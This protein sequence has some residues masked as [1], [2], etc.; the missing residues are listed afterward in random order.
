M[1]NR[2]LDLADRPARLS[3]RNSLLVVSF[4]SGSRDEQSANPTPAPEGKTYRCERLG[5]SDEPTIPLED[6]AVLIV[7]H[8]QISFSHAVL[9]GLASTGGIFVT[10]NE[11]HMPIAMLLP[12]ATHSLQ[13]ERFAA[14]AAMPLPAKK[15]IWKQIVKAKITAQARL[16]AE[17]T[18]RD[19][20]L[21][22]L[23]ARVRSGDPENIEAQAAR[24]YWPT[25]FGSSQFRRDTDG[26]GLNACLNY[27]YAIIRAI[28][29]RALCAAG[30]HPCLG[31]H[32]HNRYDPF[33]LADDLME[34]FRPIAD[35]QAVKLADARGQ[36]LEFDRDAKKTILEALSGRFAAGGES[37]SLFDWISHSASSLAAVV[38]GTYDRLDL[39]ALGP[40]AAPS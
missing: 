5:R 39:P 13:A 34:P 11:K 29:A 23:A 36:D 16:L 40:D 18:G 4:P 26:D 2:V 9:S 15:R 21:P 10:C 19:R 24:I 31:I 22:A 28:T 27:G 6:I 38:E 1:T 8:P 25:L 7:S 35:R 30:L 33:C 3:V 12:L 32:H 20:E 37:R 17:R 14:Q